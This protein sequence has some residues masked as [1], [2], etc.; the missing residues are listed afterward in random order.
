MKSWSYKQVT[1]LA[2]RQI[3]G[4]MA[5]SQN[6]RDMSR[7]S[8]SFAWGAYGFWSGLTMGWQEEGD[9]ERLKAIIKTPNPGTEQVNK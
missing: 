3:R 6:N 1:E 5:D 8:L 9:D 2:E 4:Y 7:I